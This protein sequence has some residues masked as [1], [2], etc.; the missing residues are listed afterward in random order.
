M[1]A[2]LCEAHELHL[3][4]MNY[5]VIAKKDEELLQLF[6]FFLLAGAVF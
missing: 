1:A 4:C 3:R 6:V 5:P 2:A